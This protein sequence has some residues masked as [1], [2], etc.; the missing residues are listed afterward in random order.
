VKLTRSSAAHAHD[1]QFEMALADFKRNVNLIELAS[2]LANLRVAMK[3]QAVQPD[4]DSSI[5][6]IAAAE[7]SARNGDA[8]STFGRLKSEGKWA[9]DVV[10]K[11]G[12]NLALRRLKLLSVC[13]LRH[14]YRDR[15]L[16]RRQLRIRRWSE[17]VPQFR[18]LPRDTPASQFNRAV[19][20]RRR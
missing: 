17:S 18:T 3:N 8:S 4:H 2:E 20:S 5:G 1:M 16:P 6:H 12:V 10:T 19:G 9:L 11:V 13:R 15:L 14:S 7:A